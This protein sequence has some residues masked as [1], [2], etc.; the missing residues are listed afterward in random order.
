[1]AEFAAALGTP[2]GRGTSTSTRPPS[3]EPT[4]PIKHG[5]S[6]VNDLVTVASNRE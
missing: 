6:G 1:M 5:W 2:H 3:F 4:A